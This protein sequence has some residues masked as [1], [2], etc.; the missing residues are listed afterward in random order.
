MQ[1]E[2]N[3][4]PRDGD[5]LARKTQV[6]L[7]A[8]AQQRQRSPE[9]GRAQRCRGRRLTVQEGKSPPVD[10]GSRRLP[11]LVHLGGLFLGQ[12]LRVQRAR[13]GARQFA[14]LLVFPGL[15]GVLKGLGH[16]NSA[17]TPPASQRQAHAN[18]KHHRVTSRAT[19]KGDT[20]VF[21]ALRRGN[22]PPSYSPVHLALA[23]K[24]SS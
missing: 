20:E 18:N 9:A 14:L 17:L 24:I 4:Q 22:G 15:E 16:R 3:P 19:R 23:T 7:N 1:G 8:C 5:R 12:D 13:W 6:K 21:C 2:Q 11:K 10:E